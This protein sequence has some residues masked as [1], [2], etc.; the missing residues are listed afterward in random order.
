VATAAQDG[1]ILS[2]SGTGRTRPLVA[3]KPA[4]RWPEIDFGARMWTVPGARMKSGREHR[5]PL[6]AAAIGVLKR[7]QGKDMEFLFPGTPI[8]LEF[9]TVLGLTLVL[10]QNRS[11]PG[12]AGEAAKV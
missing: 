11:S 3:A 10:N 2:Q 4:T 8:S 6:T 5:V 7:I 12:S 9:C 1:L